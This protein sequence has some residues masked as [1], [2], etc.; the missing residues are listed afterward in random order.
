MQGD[1][2]NFACWNNLI[3]PMYV[4]IEQLIEPERVLLDSVLVQIG[5]VGQ[6]LNVALPAK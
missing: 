2:D 6:V 3:I 5:Y 4:T 1:V